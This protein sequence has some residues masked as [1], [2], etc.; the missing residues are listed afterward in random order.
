MF[1]PSACFPFYVQIWLGASCSSMQT[2][3]PFC[4]TS[5]AVRQNSLESGRDDPWML[6]IFLGLSFPPRP[7]PTGPP[8]YFEEEKVFSP[9][10]KGCESSSLPQD[11]ELHHFVLSAATDRSLTHHVYFP[12]WVHGVRHFRGTPACWVPGENLGNL[13]VIV[14]CRPFLA[15]IQVLQ[16]TQSKGSF[17]DFVIPFC[18][19]DEDRSANR[20]KAKILHFSIWTVGYS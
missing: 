15:C 6:S 17:E 2:F 4:L 20:Q 19:S 14:P 5:Y 1:P 8:L 18:H 13:S 12:S 7:H 3:W 10:V 16:V 9:H 11:P